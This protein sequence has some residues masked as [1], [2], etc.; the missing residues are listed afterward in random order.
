MKR[1]YVVHLYVSSLKILHEFQWNFVLASTP[2][3]VR[4]I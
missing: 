3:V 1:I 4:K 2:N